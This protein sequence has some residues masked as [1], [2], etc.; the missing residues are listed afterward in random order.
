MRKVT[1]YINQ[2]LD[3]SALN[4]FDTITAK[5]D[6]KKIEAAITMVLG[7]AGLY[8]TY[9]YESLLEQILTKL[10]NDAR[11]KKIVDS[12]RYT[13]SLY[14]DLPDYET[15][16]TSVDE[17]Y[18]KASVEE[19]VNEIGERS[20]DTCLSD[21]CAFDCNDCSGD[22]GDGGDG[23]E[24]I[25]WEEKAREEANK[26]AENTSEKTSGEAITDVVTPPGE[27]EG[28]DGKTAQDYQNEFLA[29]ADPIFEPTF[30]NNTTGETITYSDILDGNAPPGD[31]TRVEISDGERH[32]VSV[33]VDENGRVTATI[34]GETYVI[35]RDENDFTITKV[36]PTDTKEDITFDL[37]GSNLG[38]EE[39]GTTEVGD[40]EIG[41]GDNTE[42][43]GMECGVDESCSCDGDCGSDCSSDCSSDCGGDCSSDCG[44]DCGSDCGGDCSS[45]CSSD[46]SGDCS[47]DC[48]CDDYCDCSCDSVCVDC[49][50]DCG[51]G[52]TCGTDTGCGCDDCGC[53]DWS[54]GAD[55]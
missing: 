25:R 10:S 28:T 39:L 38:N 3:R 35:A 37:G 13:S 23:G 44:G 9:Y 47:G 11:S 4:S 42:G 19:I 53:D 45:D 14:D 15:I 5:F 26:Q 31:Y 27:V 2:Q 46:C 18:G 29:N 1:E 52:D 33:T 21:G 48:G 30:E 50:S 36:D 34:D 16:Q 17:R 49:G 24:S 41:N 22:G 6:P 51:G 8:E 55:E 20:Q 7:R 12:L 54:C 40:T 32:N 43:G